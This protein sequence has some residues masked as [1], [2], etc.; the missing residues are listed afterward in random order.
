MSKPNILDLIKGTLQEIQTNNANTPNEQTADPSIFD[1]L[2]DKL[3]EVNQK[4]QTNIQTK[5][6]KNVGI[7]DV[8][9]DKI[10][11][12]QKQ[13]HDDPNA[14]TAPSSI[15]DQLRD[16][17]T[18]QKQQQEQKYQQR[19]Q[20][21]ITDIISQYNLDVRRVPQNLLQQ[22]EQKYVE[23]NRQLDHQYAQYIHELIQRSR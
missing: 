12:A 7:F 3:S 22:V 18:Q 17:V 1:F 21:S 15:F 2:K 13:N 11:S 6:G 4:T 9:L 16:R 8:I 14:R 23:A 19:S 20:D 5:E 10:S